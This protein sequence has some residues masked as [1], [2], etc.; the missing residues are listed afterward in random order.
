MAKRDYYEVLEVGKSTPQEEIKKAFRKLAMQY[1]PD[2]AKGDKKQAESEFK[3]IGEAYETLSDSGKRKNYVMY[4][5]LGSLSDEQLDELASE[6]STFQQKL[7]E[8]TKK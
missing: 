3:E 7:D 8:A 1:H 4:G 2:R 6:I 5:L